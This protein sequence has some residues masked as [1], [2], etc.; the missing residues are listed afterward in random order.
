MTRVEGNGEESRNKTDYLFIFYFQALTLKDWNRKK[1]VLESLTGS[2]TCG[3]ESEEWQAKS[4]TEWIGFKYTWVN[5]SIR[6]KMG[7]ETKKKKKGIPLSSILFAVATVTDEE[8]LHHLKNVVV[9]FLSGVS[10]CTKII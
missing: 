4:Q 9:Y 3:S 6:D 7:N 8:W 5:K 1:D 2:F 10:I